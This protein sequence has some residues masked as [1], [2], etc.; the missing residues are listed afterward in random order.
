MSEDVVDDLV[1]AVPDAAGALGEFTTLVRVDAVHHLHVLPAAP[2]LTE[3][4]AVLVAGTEGQI[5]PVLADREV[6]GGPQ[7]DASQHSLAGVVGTRSPVT[8]EGA[9]EGEHLDP[10]AHRL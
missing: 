5:D 2:D 9:A 6:T 3:G 7:T 8:V 10:V 4:L 1:P